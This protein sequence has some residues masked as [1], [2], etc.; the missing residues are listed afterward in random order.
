MKRD[1]KS[2]LLRRLHLNESWVIFFVLGIIMMD[3][4]FIQIFNV[5]AQLLGIPS[6]YLYL[7]V[8]W[9][10]SIFV[11]YLFVK[12]VDHEDGPDGERR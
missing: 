5:P 8:G 7:Y 11:I 3:F 9:M 2:S 4:P 1:L 6:L 12:S 10:V